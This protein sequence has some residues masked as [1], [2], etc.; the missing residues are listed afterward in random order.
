MNEVDNCATAL[1]DINKDEEF[2]ISGKIIIIN[3]KIPLGHKFALIDIKAEELPS[4]MNDIA[5]EQK[6]N[7][8]EVRVGNYKQS[9]LTKA[10]DWKGRISGDNNTLDKAYANPS[11]IEF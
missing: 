5:M 3:E 2:H 8:Y 10:L 7:F 9:T 4:W 1:V 11:S 6:S